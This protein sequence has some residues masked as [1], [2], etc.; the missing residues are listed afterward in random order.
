MPLKYL[1]ELPFWKTIRCFYNSALIKIPEPI[2]V[3]LQHYR[4]TGNLIINLK[5]PSTFSVKIQRRKIYEKDSRMPKL[6]D[7]IEV[8]AFVASQIGSGWI[9]PTYYAGDELPP[10]EMRKWPIP[11][12]IKPSH[13]SGLVIFIKD[14]YDIDW[15]KIDKEIKLWRQLDYG[16]EKFEWSYRNVPKRILVE[17]YIGNQDSHPFDY[18]FFVFNGKVHA[19]EVDI[20]RYGHHRQ[21]FFDRD[22]N[23]MPFRRG[24]PLF[25][26]VVPRPSRLDEMVSAAEVLG[27]GW[28][29]VRIDLYEVDE[30]P[31]FGEFT[32]YPSSGS[33]QFY[34]PVWEKT[35]GDLWNI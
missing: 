1:R 23:R 9:I 32:F 35:F 6:V 4:S 19:I 14:H 17:E 11:Y 28:P 27:K 29:F 13:A 33:T 12:V 16:R 24:R 18:K 8:K 3:R 34:P 30:I 25:D 31:Y 26:G 20:D 2:G 10:V 5:N 15:Q 21:A 7:K 22:W